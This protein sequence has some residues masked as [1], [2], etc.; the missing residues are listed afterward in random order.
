[1]VE[2]IYKEKVE[3]DDAR[4]NSLVLAHESNAKKLTTILGLAF[5]VML[6][7][8]SRLALSCIACSVLLPYVLLR[9]RSPFLPS[10]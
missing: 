6:H 8:V 9:F 5:L 4:Q 10:S 7:Q 1:M 3:I 2:T